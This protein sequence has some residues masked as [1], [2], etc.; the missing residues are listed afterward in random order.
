MSF[1]SFSNK[2]PQAKDR[3]TEIAEQLDDLK[4]NRENLLAWIKTDSRTSDDGERLTK[5]NEQ[6]AELE[7]EQAAL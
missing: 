5:I 1:F 6:I 7:R 2:E 4:K 3:K